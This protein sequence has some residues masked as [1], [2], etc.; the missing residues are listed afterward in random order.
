MSHPSDGIEVTATVAGGDRAIV[1]V[2]VVGEFDSTQVDRFRAVATPDRVDVEV[3]T[4]DIS[5]CTVLDSASLGALIDLRHHL[6]RAGGR[7]V[8]VADKPFQRVILAQTG[9][10]EYLGLG[11]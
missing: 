2:V 11:D 5:G 4:V 6:D 10:G 7:L 9:L 1:T 8:V 3:V